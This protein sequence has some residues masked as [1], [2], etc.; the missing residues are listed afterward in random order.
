M[1]W[2]NQ[3][4]VMNCFLC[5][6]VCV[7]VILFHQQR[8]KAHMNLVFFVYWNT[9]SSSVSLG[10][11]YVLKSVVFKG[12]VHP[13]FIQFLPLCHSKS[14]WVKIFRK[15]MFCLSVQWQLVGSK[16]KLFQTP[17]TFSVWI[18]TSTFLFCI[19]NDARVS[20]NLRFW[21]NYPFKMVVWHCNFLLWTSHDVMCSPEFLVGL[22]F[23]KH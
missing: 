23:L 22:Y 19:W 2:S 9:N 3:C 11:L 10:I 18:N 17:L 6:C 5:V 12:V 13:L 14:V 4:N 7:C 8:A 1:P 15:C 20:L 16:Q 21:V